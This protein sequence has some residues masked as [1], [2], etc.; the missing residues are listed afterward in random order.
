[1]ASIG[2]GYDLSNSVFSPDG[3]NF[4]V[5]YAAKA[6][7][8]GSTAVG[9]KCNDGVVLAVEKIQQSKLM[10]PNANRRI[11]AIGKHCACT[12]AGIVA[13]GRHLVSHARAEAKQWI[14]LYKSPVPVPSLADRL[15]SYV[16]AH[17][18]YNSVRPFGIS[19]LVAGFDETGPHL[20]MIEPSGAYWGYRG[21]AAGRGR[22]TARVQ[23]EKLSLP[24]IS[25]E[26]A[27]KAAAR[28]IYLAHEE[29]KEKDFE[30]EMIW[31]TKDG[32]QQIPSDL[33][34]E[35]ERLAQDDEDDDDEDDND[36]QQEDAE[37][38]DD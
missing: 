5:E 20:Y 13:D 28:I 22:Q 18:L 4:Q 23:L 14:D 29:S 12:Y 35:A 1:M 30:L 36:D 26:D 27:V 11:Q 15:G 34:A 17:T 3:R 33:L 2:T 8:N 6:V 10:K 38:K 7:E 32:Q 19:A 9:I 31:V 24:D 25:L 16:Q 21:A 37:M